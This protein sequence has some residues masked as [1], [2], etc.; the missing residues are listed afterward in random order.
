MQDL[1]A[2]SKACGGV[3][4][5]KRDYPFAIL[6]RGLSNGTGKEKAG[7]VFDEI[8]PGEEEY[9]DFDFLLYD[10]LLYTRDAMI[11]ILQDRN[12]SILFRMQLVLALGRDVQKQMAKDNIFAID[13]VVDRYRS[14]ETARRFRKELDRRLQSRK[15]T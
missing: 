13:G 2:L 10:K 3:W 15:G 4:G 6:S 5:G 7:K 1:Q 12:L 8:V 14:R 9:E 11:S